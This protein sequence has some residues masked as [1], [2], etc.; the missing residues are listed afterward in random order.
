MTYTVGRLALESWCV[1]WRGPKYYWHITR[2]K[3]CQ[4][5]WPK[6]QLRVYDKTKRKALVSTSAGKYP[7]IKT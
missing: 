7:K 2:F 4:G 1:S 3:R 6:Y 5:P